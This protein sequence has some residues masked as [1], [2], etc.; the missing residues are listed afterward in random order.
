MALRAR[1]LAVFLTLALAIGREARAHA[2]DRECVAN[3]ERADKLRRANKLVDARTT[4]QQCMKSECPRSVQRECS[5][6]MS[7]VLSTLP[8][9]VPGARD[10][11]GRDLVDVR[12]S[13][14]GKLATETLDGKALAID[15]G[16]HVFRF[17][18]R[19]AASLEERVVVRPGEKNRPVTITFATPEE[20][21]KPK[22]KAATKADAEEDAP[23]AA[24]VVGGIGLAALGA[25][26]LIDLNASANA[27]ELR[28]TCAP[29][30]A[31]SE[32]DAI[33]DRYLLAGVTAAI[34]GAALIT[35]VVLFFTHGR[36][37][38]STQSGRGFV[39]PNFAFGAG[40]NVIH[41]STS[42]RAATLE[43]RF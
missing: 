32:V 31:E 34:G 41:G 21:E 3:A 18:L 12:V 20:K 33:R 25:A 36:K 4:L 29:N 15:P 24:Y 14:D 16:V 43:L 11:K 7:D 38:Q 37:A 8:S 2:D 26:L 10:A 6:A 27:R 1:G 40:G 39:L 5:Q 22:E 28:A 30:C 19:G 42:G 9:V 23:I 13:I 17:E 35:G